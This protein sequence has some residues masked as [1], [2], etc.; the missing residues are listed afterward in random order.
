MSHEQKLHIAKVNSR[1]A[2]HA[3]DPE[4]EAYWKKV[5]RRLE[6]KEK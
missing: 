2:A 3:N 4:G 6:E 1:L 5:V